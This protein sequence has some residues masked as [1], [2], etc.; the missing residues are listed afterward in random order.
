MIKYHPRNSPPKKKLYI[1]RLANYQNPNEE[2]AV[3]VDAS[4]MY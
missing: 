3:F 2:A 4:S 1:H